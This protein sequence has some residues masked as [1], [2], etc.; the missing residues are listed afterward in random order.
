M[1]N[2]QKKTK[3]ELIAELN[4]LRKHVGN[5]ESALRP[6]K[7]NKISRFRQIVEGL[8]QFVYELDVDGHFTYANDHAF[9][10]FG[11]TRQE[12]EKGMHF[13]QLMHPDSLTE[14]RNNMAR[15][16]NGSGPLG[17]TYL[18]IRKDRT[19]FP[20]KA[21]SQAILKNGNPIGLR[22]VLVDITDV[23]QARDAL[24][25]SETY[26]RALFENTGTASVVFGQDSIIRSCNS[27]YAR[28]AGYPT[29]EIEGKMKWSDFVDPAD[30]QRMTKYHKTRLKKGHEAPGDHEFTFLPQDGNP[31]RVHV[32]IQVIP[33]T[34][35][36]TASLIDITDQERIHQALRQS[37]ERYELVV[38]GANDGIWDWNLTTDAV[39]Y[40]PRYKAILGYSDDDFPNTADSWKNAIHPDDLAQVI[41]DNWQCIEDKVDHFQTEFRMLHKDGTYRWI[42][43]R[44]A[45]AK[46]D[47][48][49]VYRLAGT[50]TDIS[51]RK[52]SE[53]QFMAVFEQ[54]AVGITLA[55]L[56]GIWL[57][58]NPS[59]TRITG[60]SR[61]ELV[62]KSI[63][64][65]T[66]PED[67]EGSNELMRRLIQGETDQLYIEKRYIHKDGNIVWVDLAVT[68]RK[69]ANG[70]PLYFMAVIT[71][72]TAR[73]QTEQ[74]LKDSEERYRNIVE[75]ASDGIYQ[76]TPDGRFRA[77]NQALAEHLGYES[78]DE[79]THTMSNIQNTLWVNPQDRTD[80]IKTLQKHGSLE[81]YEKHVYRKDGSKIWV[82]ENVRALYDENGEFILY[83]GFLQ[84]ITTRKLNERT[85][86]ALYAISKAISTTRNLQD[87]YETIHSILGEV[88]DATNFF[89]SILDEEKDRLVFTYFEDEKDDYYDIRNISDPKTKSL[90]AHVIRT[91]K[92][93]FL[94]QANPIAPQIQELI[95]VVGTPAAVWLGLP[96]IVQGKIIGAMAIQHYSNPH[97]YSDADVSLM[98]AVSEHVALAIERKINEEALTQL[99]EELESK[100]DQ[101]TKELR[102]KAVELETANARLKELDK[103]KSAIV[104]SISHELRTPLTSIRGFAKLT[105]KDFVR[106]F[107]PLGHEKILR[108]KGERIRQNLEIIETEGERLTRLINDFLD[109]NRIESGKACWSDEFLNPCDVIRQATNAVAGSFAA[110]PETSLITDLPKTIPPIHADPDKVQQVLINL[111]NNACK[112]TTEGSVTVSVIGNPDTLT[113]TVADTGIGISEQ[114]QPYIFEKFHKS[115]MGDTIDLKDKG[116]GLGLAI[117]KEIVEHYGGS[118]WVK[119]TPGK[120]S[121]FSFTLP[122]VPGTETACS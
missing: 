84:N 122:L 105:G 11:F 33:G 23:K 40:S 36:R 78:A 26:Y 64:S 110:K 95:G 83:E 58:V 15:V 7:S 10:A 106:H 18:A 109:I 32:F 6:D 61:D 50:H 75:H 102:D 113:V 62:G 91:G 70:D 115:R 25:K 2:D 12:I 24:L 42:L 49:N 65:V 37:E 92:P 63:A 51:D 71:D 119:S 76:C 87:L 116:T 98:E 86:Q 20:I 21:Y 77:A 28:L 29:H 89:I 112:F 104:S 79:L 66:H 120:G 73:K 68:M 31:K 88:I 81:N 54:A 97:H 30:I 101:R 35:S 72:N 118:I 4:R 80:F 47:K 16:L 100:V 44:G 5:T 111:L 13:S 74:A 3:A 96:L 22:G 52:E 39:Y 19:T 48:G 41:E 69:D 45:S 8:P 34:E 55:S 56:D 43:G 57:Q 117:C 9:T 90:A 27:Q 67:Q 14:A 38:R 60:Y 99:N 93:L 121:E 1:K 59:M 53:A 46:N 107:Q 108:K 85:T 17:T 103:I 114:D 82:S 94:S